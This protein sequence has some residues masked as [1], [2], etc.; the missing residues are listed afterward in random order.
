MKKL[1]PAL[2]FL[3]GLAAL[4]G[5][6]GCDST[7]DRHP[8]ETQKVV[9]SAAHAAPDVAMEVVTAVQIVLPAGPPGSGGYIGEITANNVKVLE[10]MEPMRA[11]PST[12]PLAAPAATVTFYALKPGRSV[13]RFA[14][15]RPGEAEA[16]P[17]AKCEVTVRVA[18]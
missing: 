4:F 11:A 12:D 2:I 10:E 15:V 5:V 1:P 9:L 7:P 6:S 18:D 8:K 14:L 3:S 16:I 13:L 17:A